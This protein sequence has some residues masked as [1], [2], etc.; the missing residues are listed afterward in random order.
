LAFLCV[1]IRH[2]AIRIN[3]LSTAHTSGLSDGNAM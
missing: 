2:S 3:H 1:H